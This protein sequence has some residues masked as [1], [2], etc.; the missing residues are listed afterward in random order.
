MPEEKTTRKAL[1]TGGSR[2]IGKATALRLADEGYDVAICYVRSKKEGEEV[3]RLIRTTGVKG[4]A[5]Q[6]DLSKRAAAEGVVEK[7]ARFLGGLDTLVNNAGIYIRSKFEQLTPQAWH[8]TISTNLDSVFYTSR[9]A[10][11]YMKEGKFGR[12]VNL[13]SILAHI[14]SSQG[15]DYAASKA[16]IIGFTR[17]LAIE[18]AQY[19][20][21]V[22]AVASGSVETAIIG[23]DTP[24]VRKERIKKIPLGRVGQ[25]ED[26]AGVVSFL[27]SN[28]AG[29]ITGQ[30]LNA[31]GGQFML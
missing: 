16:G 21:T 12:I 2:G 4:V 17:S 1:V 23:D 3:A 5:F 15:A 30:T 27:V 6:A 11:P 7:A 19:G 26:I 31:N 22:N 13:T 8:R 9:A 29:Y 28:D 10:I 24:E 25:P 18:L 20:I 14:G